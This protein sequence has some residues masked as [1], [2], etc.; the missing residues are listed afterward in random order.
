LRRRALGFG[1]IPFYGLVQNNSKD[2][3]VSH[4]RIFPLR[5]S[6]LQRHGLELVGPRGD[7]EYAIERAG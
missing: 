5:F 3:Y 6:G 4:I 1:D 7:Q 2:N